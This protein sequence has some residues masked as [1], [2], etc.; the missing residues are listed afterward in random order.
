[1][2]LPILVMTMD[3]VVRL[4]FDAAFVNGMSLAAIEGVREGAQVFP[5]SLPFSDPQ[6]ES[7]HQP[8][9]GDDVVDRVTWVVQQRLRLLRLN[10]RSPESL[11]LQRTGPAVRVVLRRGLQIFERGDVRIPLRPLQPTLRPDELEVIIAVRLGGSSDDPSDS[12]Q[13]GLGAWFAAEVLQA[14][15]RATYE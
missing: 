15:A 10:V 2:A 14:S 6:V 12:R 7:V 5:R 4:T 1:M 8:L 11:P 3:Y 13:S 9:D